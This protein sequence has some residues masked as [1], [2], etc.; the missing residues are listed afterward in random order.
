MSCLTS[1][2]VTDVACPYIVFPRGRYL[3]HLVGHEGEGSLLSLLKY[4]GWANRLSAGPYESSTDWSNFV[5]SVDCTERGMVRSPRFFPFSFF[6]FVYFFMFSISFTF[7][8][9]P[10]FPFSISSISLLYVYRYGKEFHNFLHSHSLPRFNLFCTAFVPFWFHIPLFPFFFPYF[11]R[12]P[13]F[14]S[15]SIRVEQSFSFPH[16]RGSL[17]F[18]TIKFRVGACF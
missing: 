4:K 1:S 13:H 17:F 11:T 6:F 15:F 14:I 12:Q 9:L 7:P 10:F 5:V 18:S 16:Y 2:A 8:L 3:S